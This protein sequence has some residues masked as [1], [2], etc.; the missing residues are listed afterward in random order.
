MSFSCAHW[1]D[2]CIFIFLFCCQTANESV[3]NTACHRR[4]HFIWPCLLAA[5]CNRRIAFP[6]L[7]YMAALRK[8]VFML[9]REEFVGLHLIKLQHKLCCVYCC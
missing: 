4:Y 5:D 2:L 8:V 6:R 9:V 1:V 7:M 3:G